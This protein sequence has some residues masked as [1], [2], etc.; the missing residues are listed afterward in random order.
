MKDLDENRLYVEKCF[1]RLLVQNDRKQ[2]SN[3]TGIRRE[4]SF[5]LN[6]NRSRQTK[7]FGKWEIE[8]F[9]PVDFFPL[10][11]NRTDPFLTD[12]FEIITF[13]D[14]TPLERKTAKSFIAKYKTL[15]FD[16][17]N[18]VYVDNRTYFIMQPISLM[19]QVHTKHNNLYLAIK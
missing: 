13:G 4:S 6:T 10:A 19:K 18:K 17:K 7:W 16:D 14:G 8:K 11:M 5:I 3:A 15:S 2:I 12:L 1:L 9:I